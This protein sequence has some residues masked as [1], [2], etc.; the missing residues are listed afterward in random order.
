[1]SAAEMT[2]EQLHAEI[3]RLETAIA[4]TERAGAE[5]LREI[6]ERF[7]P[8]IAVAVAE[9]DAIEGELATTTARLQ[10][11]TARGAIIRPAPGAQWKPQRGDA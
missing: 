3:A 8:Q 1:M 7:A 6:D 4:D 2:E 11:L 10:R 9:R 5:R